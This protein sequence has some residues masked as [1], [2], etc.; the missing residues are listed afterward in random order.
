MK[1]AEVST[2]IIDAPPPRPKAPAPQF[3]IQIEEPK[4]ELKP[5]STVE[6]SLIP[7]I[8]GLALMGAGMAWAWVTPPYIAEIT[9]ADHFSFAESNDSSGSFQPTITSRLV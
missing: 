7:W 6:W 8:V 3:A 2:P 4:K 5:K 1:E 9:Q